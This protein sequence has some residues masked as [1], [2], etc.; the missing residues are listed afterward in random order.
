MVSECV[1]SCRVPTWYFTV[2][3]MRKSC[4]SQI[5]VNNSILYLLRSGAEKQAPRCPACHVDVT[6][7]HILVECPLYVNERR[8]NFLLNKSL[9]EIL[10]EDASFEFIFK[11]LKDIG[12]FYSIWYFIAFHVWLILFSQIW[13]IL[14]YLFFPLIYI[15]VCMRVWIYMCIFYLA[16][17]DLTKD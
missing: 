15:H 5:A 14:C 2:R 6:V 4:W 7:K 10:D 1:S 11:F 12:L 3:Y 9:K 8:L 16:S 13:T 17:D